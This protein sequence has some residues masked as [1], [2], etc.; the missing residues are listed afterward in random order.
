MPK[1]ENDMFKSMNWKYILG[2]T[3]VSFAIILTMEL[4]IAKLPLSLHLVLN[5]LIKPF[6]ITVLME[7]VIYLVPKQDKED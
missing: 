6:L 1:G 4:T 2:C 3:A 7:R 5:S